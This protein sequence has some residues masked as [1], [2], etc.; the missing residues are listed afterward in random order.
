MRSQ[1]GRNVIKCRMYPHC[2]IIMQYAFAQILFFALVFI[3]AHDS[4]FGKEAAQTG[5]FLVCVYW[6]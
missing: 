3:S 6:R 5:S 4:I 1:K 2:I